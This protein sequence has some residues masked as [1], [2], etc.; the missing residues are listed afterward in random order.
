MSQKEDIA[1]IKKHIA[2]LNDEYG[3]IKENVSCLKTDMAVVK[4]DIKWIK[5]WGIGI[6]VIIQVL[7][8][9]LITLM[10]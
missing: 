5:T 3:N 4:N 7:V 1:D 10:T 8:S 2:T 6:L 9:V